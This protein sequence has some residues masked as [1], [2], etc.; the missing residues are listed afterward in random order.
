MG[1][2]I[3]IGY[4]CIARKREL[5]NHDICVFFSLSLSSILLFDQWFGNENDYLIFRFG[6]KIV[7]R[8]IE[9]KN[10][11][12]QNDVRRIFILVENAY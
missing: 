10:E 7:G 2:R 9:N 3:L 8:N 5:T 1:V 11:K 12:Q 6:L 4:T